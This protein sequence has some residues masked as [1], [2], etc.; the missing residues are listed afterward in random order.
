MDLC[1]QCKWGNEM[2]P[3]KATAATKERAINT[4][5]LIF[6]ENCKVLILGT[7]PGKESRKHGYYYCDKRNRFWDIIGKLFGGVP[8]NN[9]ERRDYLL[10]KGIALW[11]VCACCN[12]IGSRD[13]LIEV[14][15]A[16]PIC[17]LL[18]MMKEKGKGIAVFCNGGKAYAKYN[19]HI[20]P[21]CHVDAIKLLSTSG[22]NSNADLEKDW[23]Y[24]SDYINDKITL[25]QIM[26]NKNSNK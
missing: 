25:Q 12:I 3:K 19:E 13:D 2:S 20:K 14:V 23:Q 26:D 9:W 22:R 24:I 7:F 15:V 1:D 6:N 18:N 17:C 5:P 10:N 4:L 11:D 8:K 16:N 21:K